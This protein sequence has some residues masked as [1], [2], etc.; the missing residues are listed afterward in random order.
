MYLQV[1]VKKV[2]RPAG[3][4]LLP[5]R[6][7][8]CFAACVTGRMMSAESLRNC[9]SGSTFREDAER[10]LAGNVSAEGDDVQALLIE[11]GAVGV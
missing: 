5:M 1:N 2:W 7:F 10:L 3:E 9:N 4:L 6:W 8:S 11:D